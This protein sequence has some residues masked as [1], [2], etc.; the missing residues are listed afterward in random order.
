MTIK[1]LLVKNYTK[2]F[3]NQEIDLLLALALHKT[4]EYIYKNPDKNLCLST[5][6]TFKKLLTKRQQ[7]YSLAYLQGY[8]EFYGLKF[9]VNKHTLIPRPAS[10]LIV[11]ESLKFLSARGGSSSGRKTN[12]NYKALDIGTG[13]G[14]LIISIA[15]TRRVKNPSGG[16]AEFYASDISTPALRMAKTNARKNKVR[17]NFIKSNLFNKIPKIKFN[18][19]IANLPYLTLQQLKESSLKK[20]PRL[21]LFGGKDGLDYY[22]KLLKQVKNFLANEFVILLEI[23]P[24]QVT[25]IQTLIRKY[26]PNSKIEILKDLNKDNRV[27]KIN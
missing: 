10:E 12:K 13:S 3:P 18:L 23:D 4:P 16:G 26:L 1:Q 8:K 9:L 21:A 19:I 24:Q 20:E 25:K 22:Q 27:V 15:T 7:N 14:C 6:K 17:I 11:E 5:I 2:N